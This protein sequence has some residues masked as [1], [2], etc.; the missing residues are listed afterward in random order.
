LA[1]ILFEYKNGSTSEDYFFEY[2]CDLYF[3]ESTNIDQ[4]SVYI[5]DQYYGDDV[6][7]IQINNGDTLRID[8]VIGDLTETP[9]LQFS[10]KLV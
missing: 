7:K 6:D 3:T 8:I 5:N 1:S 9:L 2:V 10:Q 4:Y